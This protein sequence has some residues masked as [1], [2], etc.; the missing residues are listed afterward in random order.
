MN[1]YFS[2]SLVN[3]NFGLLKKDYLKDRI[4]ERDRQIFDLLVHSTNDYNGIKPEGRS[5]CLAYHMGT[6]AQALGSPST[7]F[8]GMLAGNWII[9]GATRT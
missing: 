5:L 2:F 4:S 9:N 3:L 7:V 6:G 8:L 1:Y